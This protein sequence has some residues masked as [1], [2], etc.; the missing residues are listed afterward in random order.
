MSK[1][2][3][4]SPRPADVS[5][6]DI[7][8]GIVL[9]NEA[10]QAWWFRPKDGTDIKRSIIMALVH[11]GWRPPRPMPS[12]EMDDPQVAKSTLYEVILAYLWSLGFHYY[13]RDGVTYFGHR[14][15]GEGRTFEGALA[16]AIG[17]EREG[18]DLRKEAQAA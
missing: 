2:D 1:V 12:T 13:D 17:C 8:K 9:V 3:I 14:S 10:E 15:L 7:Y 11:A 4:E 6:L 18:R 16:W 5:D